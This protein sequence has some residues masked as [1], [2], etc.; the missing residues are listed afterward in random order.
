MALQLE[1]MKVKRMPVS[2][3]VFEAMRE[4]IKN[5]V[6][7]P[8]EKIPPETE[9]S[10]IFGVNRLTVRMAMQR[11]IGMGLLESKVGDGTYVKE[12]S[13]ENYIERVSDFY[14]KPELL[15]KV[16]EFR[17]SIEID[18]V[19]LAID[20]AE[21]QEIVELEQQCQ[22]F[23]NAKLRY[24]QN[25]DKNVF[26]ELV[27]EDVEFHHMVC[28]LSHNDLFVYAFEMARE[29]IY[30]YMEMLVD[31]RVA[32]WQRQARSGNMDD[33]LHRVICRSIREKDFEACKKAY[34][35]MVDYKVDLN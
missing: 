25:K 30:K 20:R 28:K 23:E 29:L 33:D 4:A 19:R 3:Q 9:L 21:E 17:K 11:L 24:L 18:S 14:L 1:E 7:K 34:S 32:Y 26:N 10:E 2:E 5:R 15:D 31:K 13:F 12:F 16:L 8:G 27:S 35:D 22:R 6:W